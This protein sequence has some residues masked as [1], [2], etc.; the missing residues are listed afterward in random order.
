MLQNAMA[1][2]WIAYYQYWI[3]AKVARGLHRA[4]IAEELSA[5]AEEEYGH[6]EKL[7]ARIVELGGLPK[8]GPGEWDAMSPCKYDAP[9][10]QESTA[11]VRQNH[12]A[13]KCAIAFYQTILAA[14]AGTDEATYDIVLK[15]LEDENE[16]ESDLRKFLEDAEMWA[17]GQAAK[18]AAKASAKDPKDAEIAALKAQV[19]HEIEARE[20][21]VAA[22]KAKSAELAARL[23]KAFPEPVKPSAK[24]VPAKP[25]AV[26]NHL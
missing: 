10:D 7:A 20:S 22:E 17:K 1:S 2:E 18:A 3:G 25:S 24:G 16:H 14:T 9:E 21:M 8:P 26:S 4:A 6:A 15:I 11:V 13:E 5:H 19:D 12:E 23:A